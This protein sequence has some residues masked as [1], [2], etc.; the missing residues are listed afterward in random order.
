MTA[1]CPFELSL[2]QLGRLHFPK[3]WP[4][5]RS[6]CHMPLSGVALSLPHRQAGGASFLSLE[7]GYACDC[8]SHGAQ[9]KRG[10]VPPG[11]VLKGDALLPCWLERLLLEPRATSEKPSS[12]QAAVL[13]RSQTTW[14]GTCGHSR[15]S[16]GLCVVPAHLSDL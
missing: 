3:R 11:L 10:R 8:S 14:K 15:P 13:G 9:G 6:T 4:Q 5:Q 12:P 2:A 1:R 16:P 7:S